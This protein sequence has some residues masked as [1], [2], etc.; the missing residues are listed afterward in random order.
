[1][2]HIITA[3]VQNQPGVLAHVASMF[4]A[5]GF[6][7]DSL[8]VGRTDDPRRSR[9]TIAVI[10]DDHVL[11]QVRKQLE[12][13]VTVVKVRDFAEVDYIE[14]D[15]LLV[16]VH[17]PPERRHEVIELAK[18]FR[19]HV[20]DVSRTD[21]MVELSG[22]AKKLDAFIDLVRPLGICELARTG[23]IAMQRGQ[24]KLDSQTTPAKRSD[25]ITKGDERSPHRSL[26]KALGL[27]DGDLRRPLIAVCNSHSD[28]VPGHAHLD[29]VGDFV[30]RQIRQ[31]GGTPFEFHTIAI[32][33]GIAMGHSGMKYS[34]PSR[35]L[36]ADCVE[37]MV[38]AHPFDA[39][40][41][42]PNCDKIVPGMFLAALRLN[43]PTIFVSGGP[44]EAGI[45]AG[46]DVDLIDQFYAV[47]QA[48]CGAI[49][50]DQ[51]AQ[52]E[53]NTCP[54]CGS[55]SGMFTANSMN[56]LS[57]AIGMA[58]PGN[59]TCLAT[60]RARM[61]LFARAAERIV[62]M[63][64]QWSAA[65]CR[66][67]WPMLPRGIMTRRAFLN[68]MTLDMAMGGSSNTV[69]HLL[70]MAHEAG[71]KF[72]LDDIA[73]VSA[74][75]PNIC[76]IAPSAT[77]EGKI[78]HIQ[79]LHRAGGVHTIM[80]QLHLDNA[81]LLDGQCQTVDGLTMKKRL[82]QYSLRSPKCLP[83]AKKM[84]AEGSIP[85]RRTLEQVRAM[86]RGHSAFPPEESS[87]DKT[88]RGKA[89]CP[90]PAAGKR[91][92]T[93][94][95]EAEIGVS[96]LFQDIIRP[97]SRAFTLR[98]G[99]LVLYGNIAHRGGVV[100]LA[101]VDPKMYRHAGPAV[102]FESQEDACE[103][104]LGGRVK[105]GQVVV[106]RN[107]GPR[108]G[109]GMQEMLA[110]TSYLKGMG[111]GDKCVLITDGRFSGGTAGACIG[112]ISPEAAAGGEIGLLRR[113]DIIEID[114]HAG[115]INARVSAVE[116]ARRKKKSKRQITAGK[117][118]IHGALARYAHHATSAD[119]G[120][121]LKL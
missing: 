120:G 48:Q 109:P 16:R 37:S 11:E 26:L 34:L 24:Q 100:K 97:L 87:C 15:L 19:G 98:G 81:R 36:I 25:A 77:P 107:E 22:V 7:I 103:G 70:A 68:A 43:I 95:S 75:T 21:V 4:S 65:K 105:P 8:V 28:I 29:A 17:A 114:L 115:T 27:N 78:Y 112:H 82:E 40:I 86:Y 116:F 58:L 94:I 61:D 53:N 60:S 117:S 85:T 50:R 2:K 49:S 23:I 62:E 14:R 51:L 67:D 113:G 5:R 91:G 13:I 47:A 74:R 69:L 88:L 32:C 1:M 76:R 66:R 72:T 45:V 80:H 38:R 71:V 90:L 9:M 30:K 84:Y 89:E 118:A 108:G 42:I 79:D 3:I 93:P 10:G 55:C 121:I 41:C 56:C 111:L 31:A 35:D 6:N 39:M 99:L 102:I 12:K 33:D 44:M 73:A 63:A 20:V 18:L 59:G 54:T 57:E 64:K 104:I 119:Q 92:Q 101:G 46:K 106:I 96:P 52:Y 83:A 110:P